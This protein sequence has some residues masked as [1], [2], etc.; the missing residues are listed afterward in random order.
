MASHDTL[1]GLADPTWAAAKVQAREAIIAVARR[2]TL[3]TYSD[4]AAAI[5]VCDLP[6]HDTRLADLLGEISTEEAHAGRGMLTV[7]V[8]H[9]TG[10][11]RPGPG[12]FKLAKSLG[13]DTDD[14]DRLWID[15]LTRVYD[16]WSS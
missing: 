11:R 6:P 16:V 10:D 5:T 14:R 13:R 1:H 2:K 4:L 8:V 15:E 9:K 12:F 7:A 3:I